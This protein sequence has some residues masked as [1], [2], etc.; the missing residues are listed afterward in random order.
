MLL[1]VK[2][3]YTATPL[4]TVTLHWALELSTP[5]PL[6]VV[7]VPKALMHSPPIPQVTTILVLETQQCEIIQKVA[8]TLQL[9]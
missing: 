1:L 7:I 8:I 2:M 9:V 4:V 3:L 6:V 5:I